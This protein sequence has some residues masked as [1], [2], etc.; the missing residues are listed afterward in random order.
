MGPAGDVEEYSVH[1]VEEELQLQVVAPRE[2]KVEEELTQSFEFNQVRLLF[3]I[4]LSL[5][6]DLPV[7]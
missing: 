3:R 2:A 5:N 1:E 6:V 7:L 4:S